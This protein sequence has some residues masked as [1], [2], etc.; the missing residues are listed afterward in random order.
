VI[1]WL[2]PLIVT[3]QELEEGLEIYAGALDKAARR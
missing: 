3:E 1:R 2:P